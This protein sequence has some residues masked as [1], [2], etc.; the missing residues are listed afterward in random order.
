MW[1]HPHHVLDSHDKYYASKLPQNYTQFLRLH[2]N[3][4]H[5]F[6]EVIKALHGRNS[7]PIRVAWELLVVQEIKSHGGY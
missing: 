2:N 7:E 1:A 4:V 3:D 5:T 6:K